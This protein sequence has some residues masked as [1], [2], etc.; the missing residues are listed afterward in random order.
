MT[1]IKS[2]E[3]YSTIEHIMGYVPVVLYPAVHVGQFK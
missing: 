1:S 3:A 2:Q